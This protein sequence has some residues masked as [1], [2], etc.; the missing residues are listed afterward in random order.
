MANRGMESIFFNIG[1]A[2][3]YGDKIAHFLLYGMMAMSLNLALRC[4][5]YKVFNVPV[6]L[7]GLLVFWFAFIEEL[8]QYLFPT[9]N[10]D[11]M[12]L[13]AD[14]AGILCF[15]YLSRIIVRSAAK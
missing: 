8:T 6:Q 9:R 5:T 2:I 7:G 4:R 3:P 15:N 1:D 10:L 14:I 13:I 11:I 12:D